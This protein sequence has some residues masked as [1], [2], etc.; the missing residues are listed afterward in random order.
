LPATIGCGT[1]TLSPR[2]I[3]TLLYL[4]CKSARYSARADLRQLKFADNLPIEDFF[5]TGAVPTLPASA[6][7][8]L[9]T[10]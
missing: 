5:A 3:D 4:I 1:R 2:T 8:V 7:G 6:A 9:S 10:F